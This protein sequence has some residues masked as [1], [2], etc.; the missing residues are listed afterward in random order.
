VTALARR[1]LRIESTQPPVASLAALKSATS[2]FWTHNVYSQSCVAIV[3]G[4][5]FFA[6]RTSWR[7]FGFFAPGPVFRGVIRPTASGSELSGCFTVPIAT[8]L[9]SLV[10][11]GVATWAGLSIITEFWRESFPLGVTIL[12]AGVWCTSVGLGLRFV[13]GFP[14]WF[15]SDVAFIER[16]LRAALIRPAA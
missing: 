11:F 15:E 7:G 12:V 14:W 13:L 6:W 2:R 10:F 4:R 9:F 3:I 16:H 5:Y 1:P 8:L